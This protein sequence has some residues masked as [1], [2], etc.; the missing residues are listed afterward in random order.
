MVVYD[1]DRLIR[2]IRQDNLYDLFEP[3]YRTRTGFAMESFLVSREQE[4]RIDLVCNEIYGSVDEVDV[5]MSINQI[6]NPLNIKEGDTI[7][8]VNYETLQELFILE[9]HFYTKKH[10]TIQ[11]EKDCC[12]II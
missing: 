5:I 8:F 6:D 3:T 2:D 9:E 11:K 10:I 12:N 1:I 4:M 7:M